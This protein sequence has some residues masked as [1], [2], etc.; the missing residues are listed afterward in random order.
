MFLKLSRYKYKY[1]IL[2]KSFAF[3]KLLLCFVTKYV[4]IN[5]NYD[6]EKLF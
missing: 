2:F 3:D 4:I 1:D 5:H 6:L